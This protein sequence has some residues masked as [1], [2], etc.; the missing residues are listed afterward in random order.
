ML[1]P[2][3]WVHN[4]L[5][6]NPDEPSVHLTFAIRER[7]PVWLAE[8]LMAGAIESASFRNIIRPG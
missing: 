2:R 8:K 4:P 1:L 7:A 5:V 3:G 6:R